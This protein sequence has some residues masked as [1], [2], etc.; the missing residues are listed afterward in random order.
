MVEVPKVNGVVLLSL[1]PAGVE[2]EA[3]VDVPKENK[4]LLPSVF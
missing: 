2:V 4:F 3:A 1:F